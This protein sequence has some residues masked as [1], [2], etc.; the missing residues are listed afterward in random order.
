MNLDKKSSQWDNRI[1][2]DTEEDGTQPEESPSESIQNIPEEEY[3]A[4]LKTLE[5]ILE[6]RNELLQEKSLENEP[7]TTPRSM[8][9]SGQDTKTSPL[10]K[11]FISFATRIGA[12][13]LITVIA[14]TFFYGIHIV[15]DP[16][17]MPVAQN[18]EVVLLYRLNRN[19]AINDL[20]LLNFE[21]TRQ[22]R[23]V[24]AR[25]GDEVDFYEGRLKINGMLQSDLHAR[26]ETWTFEE[27]VEFP[28]IVPQGELFLLGDN[29]ENATDSRIYGT[30]SPRDT[31]GRIITIIRRRDL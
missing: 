30:V 26:G 23:R 16:G 3:S 1:R 31:Y 19:Y 18:G 8:Q 12:I 14:F 24:I 11:E 21:G 15:A 7:H 4:A 5:D 9:T 13:V 27:G 2:D 25:A 20:V 29:R 28:I 6:K 22:I 10:L 17:M